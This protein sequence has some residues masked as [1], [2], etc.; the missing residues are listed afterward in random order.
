MPKGYWIVNNIVRD[1]A[2][3]DL[4]RAANAAP[5]AQY[6][7]RFLVRGGRQTATEGTPHPRSVVLEFPSYD[8]ALACYH[9]AGYAAAR[10]LRA[11]AAEG[12]FIIVEGYGD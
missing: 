7:A 4:Y 1:S 8:A 5:L 10:A 2:A 9:D 12:T 11:A 3:Y 6:G